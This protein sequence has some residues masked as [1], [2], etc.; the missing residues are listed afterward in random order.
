MIRIF[1]L[2]QLPLHNGFK[3]HYDG[4]Q[5]NLNYVKYAVSRH[6]IVFSTPDFKRTYKY[7]TDTPTYSQND[8]LF[9]IKTLHL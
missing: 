5:K 8:V 2:F 1:P 7:N 9:K 6:L 3:D 4:K